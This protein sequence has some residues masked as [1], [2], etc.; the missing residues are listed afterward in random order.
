MNWEEMTPEQRK[1]AFD[2]ASSLNLTHA[3]TIETLT[4]ERD[5][6]QDLVI[7]EK[8]KYQELYKQAFTSKVAKVE[9]QPVTPKT[10]DEIGIK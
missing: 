9:T 2:N 1:E 6:A 10:L 8:S 4:G 7:A 5:T 3:T